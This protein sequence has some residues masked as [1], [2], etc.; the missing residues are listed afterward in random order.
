MIKNGGTVEKIVVTNSGPLTGT[1]SIDGAKNAA[2]PIIAASLLGTEP[3]ILENVPKLSD[4]EVILEVLKS[5]GAKV[6][7]LEKNTVQIDSSNLT[8]YEA[9]MELMNRMRASF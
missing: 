2:L 3:I 6:E 9:P 7:F 4:I 5:L 8:G 1:V